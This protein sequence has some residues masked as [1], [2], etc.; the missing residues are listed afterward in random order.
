M[1][2]WVVG[3]AWLFAVLFAAVL[4]GFTAY[5]LSWK[6]RRLQADRAKLETLLGRVAVTGA[7]LQASGERARDLSA[8]LASPAGEPATG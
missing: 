8:R 3:G 2:G 4:F 1:Q 5:E 6:A 7:E